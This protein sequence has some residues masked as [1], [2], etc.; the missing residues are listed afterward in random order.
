MT[1]KSAV[2]GTSSAVRVPG[3]MP[4]GAQT[5]GDVVDPAGELGERHPLGGALAEPGLEEP[6]ARPGQD[7]RRGVGTGPRVLVEQRV[8]GGGVDD[9]HAGSADGTARNA[10]TR[11]TIGPGT[12]S[13]T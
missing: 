10:P 8:E 12:S 2:G 9:R 6:E 13:R 11:S 5:G 4:G 1:K 3:P 7:E